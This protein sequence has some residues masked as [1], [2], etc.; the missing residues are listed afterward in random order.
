MNIRFSTLIR[1]QFRQKLE[2]IVLNC[3]AL[4]SEENG[5][6]NA[7]QREDV[8]IILSS[9]NLLKTY[10]NPTYGAVSTTSL[11]I[12]INSLIGFPRVIQEGIDGDITEAQR[13]TLKQ[14]EN[15]GMACLELVHQQIKVET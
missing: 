4:L 13:N 10:L 6:L 3:Y 1:D 5:T 8:D 12:C 7:D 15:D 2:H 11:R 14:M 9:A